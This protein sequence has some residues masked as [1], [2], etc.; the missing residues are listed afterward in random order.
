VPLSPPTS[1]RLQS[2]L[3]SSMPL[4]LLPMRLPL[5]MLLLPSFLLSPLVA[6][7]VATVVI[8]IEGIVVIAKT[9]WLLPLRESH[10]VPPMVL[11]PKLKPPG[12]YRRVPLLAL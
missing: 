3:L 5:V 9:S 6:V 10:V 2:T 8:D 12:S 11:M 4:L 7:S 1:L